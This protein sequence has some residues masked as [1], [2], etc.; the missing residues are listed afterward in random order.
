VSRYFNLRRAIIGAAALAALLI[1]AY[2]LLLNGD[3][4]IER[5]RLL[6]TRGSDVGLDE[7]KLAP[8]FELPSYDGDSLRLSDLRGR[9]LLINFW[10]TWC[11]SCLSEMPEIAELQQDRGMDAFGV[12]AI[13]AGESREAAGKFIDF[14]GARFDYG[15]DADLVV[16]DAYGVYGL[17]MS[18][19]LDAGGIV[20]AVYRGHADRARLEV[21]LDAAVQSRKPPELP[22]QVRTVSTIPRERL[23]TVSRPSESTVLLRSRSLR[24]DTS[25]CAETAVGSLNGV[26]GVLSTNWTPAETL[27]WLR[28]RFNPGLTDADAIAEALAAALEASKDPLYEL[29]VDVRYED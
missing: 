12:L 21:F 28:V 16:A 23:L 4:G 8:D 18:V 1:P 22:V 25:Y 19:F 11:G 26:A 20:R 17:P 2:L 29:P 7:G 13:N 10:A 27:P 14:L 3:D 24:C 9:P 5:A 6:G 15:L